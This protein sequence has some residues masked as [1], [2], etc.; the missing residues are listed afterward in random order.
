MI[1]F[2][3]IWAI[4][5]IYVVK[6]YAKGFAF[7]AIISIMLTPALCLKYTSPA[8]TINYALLFQIAII[9]L[10]RYVK[11]FKTSP[12][13]KSSIL[14]VVINTI[15]LFLS[16]YPIIAVLS[17]YL[18]NVTQICFILILT[19]TNIFRGRIYYINN[20]ILI[21]GFV[22]SVYGI[23][24][25]ITQYNFFFQWITQI[26]PQ[27][28]LQGKLF[29]TPDYAVRFN[30]IR[31]QSLFMHSIS[32]SAVCFMYIAY[33][34]IALKCNFIKSKSIW[35][36]LLALLGIGIIS[37]GSRSPMLALVIF[38]IPF[39]GKMKL[40]ISLQT[41]FVACGFLA[42]G[43][44]YQEQI[45]GLF[46]SLFNSNNSDIV[47]SSSDMRMIQLA[48]I[49][50]AISENPILGLGLKGFAYALSN[51]NSEDLYG[52]ESEWFHVLLNYGFIGVFVN[53][54]YYYTL[55]KMRN[56]ISPQ[57]RRYMLFFVISW[58]VFISITS[59]PGVGMTFFT[60]IYILLYTQFIERKNDRVKS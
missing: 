31:C 3:I 38:S 41:V 43:Y 52:A 14:L 6:N 2:I 47:G 25:Y 18:L 35:Y 22:F 56:D 59:T 51:I 58:I 34:I 20:L 10:R 30:S 16:H 57:Y 12:L 5:A 50:R 60:T 24:E 17:D 36:I 49:L 37:S 26:I 53:I 21:S 7:Y 15:S 13:Y 46:I 42:L 40:R 54:Y 1:V 11:F 44:L 4:I 19:S 9:G 29:L 45:L 55:S 27:E 39:L 28:L 32:Y 33:I 8:L 23:I 48:T